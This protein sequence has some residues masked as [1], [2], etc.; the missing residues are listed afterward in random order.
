MC[1]YIYHI[2]CY[3]LHIIYIKYI[4][5]HMHIYMYVCVCMYIYICVYIY[6]YMSMG[7][8]QQ[9]YWI[10][11]PFPPPRDL[12]NPGIKPKSPESPVLADRF[13]I[14][15]P[16]LKLHTHT[17]TYVE[18]RTTR[19]AYLSV[20]YLFKKYWFSWQDILCIFLHIANNQDYFS[21]LNYSIL[22]FGSGGLLRLID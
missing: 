9:E 10:R 21:L 7:F 2:T 12:P 14:T 11:L 20:Y 3:R 13:F 8:P 5:M 4:Y 22:T 15:E 1:I 19:K 17:L 16:S 18:I 6:I